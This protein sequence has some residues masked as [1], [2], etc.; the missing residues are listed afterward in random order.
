MYKFISKFGLYLV[1]FG[2]AI[3]ISSPAPA[4]LADG[5]S[6]WINGFGYQFLQGRLSPWP[7]GSN[8][9]TPLYQGDSL[10]LSQ[11]PV[12]GS[13]PGNDTVSIDC[14]NNGTYNDTASASS[15]RQYVNNTPYEYSSTNLR[16]T[17]PTSGTY[18]PRIHVVRTGK[19][20]GC[21]P[22]ANYSSY[23][24]W[25]DY[26]GVTETIDYYLSAFSV[27]S[28][29]YNVTVI[30][31]TEYHGFLANNFVCNSSTGCGAPVTMDLVIDVNTSKISYYGGP[32][33][34]YD[35]TGPFTYS[36]DC[37]GDGKIDKVVSG[38]A[39]WMTAYTNLQYDPNTYRSHGYWGFTNITAYDT[40]PVCS[41]TSPGVYNISVAVD[42]GGLPQTEYGRY[43]LMIFPSSPL[44][45]SV[46]TSPSTGEA[47]LNSVTVHAVANNIMPGTGTWGPVDLELSCEGNG[48]NNAGYDIDFNTPG[49]PMSSTLSYD[50][51][52]T[53]SCSY[54]TAGTHTPTV[55]VSQPLQNLSAS[56][57]AK[58]YV[59]GQLKCDGTD[60]M[61]APVNYRLDW[62]AENSS[63]C[64]ASTK[65]SQ[66]YSGM[67]Y[68]AA[69]NWTGTKA[70]AGSQT[71]YDVPAGNYEY[72][73]SCVGVDPS[74]SVQ[75]SC[76]VRVTQ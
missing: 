2:S 25:G 33:Y 59:V 28:Q 31:T 53:N 10:N 22:T 68:S 30:P 43:A 3:V 45:V 44:S 9:G 29:N 34:S 56:G 38:S 17:Y 21:G 19:G 74:Q 36:I 46:K 16:C 5:N 42:G 1:I 12:M 61:K 50:F 65:L 8:Y 27:L 66:S 63:K 23:Y 48:S 64:I 58:V 62:A 70:A 40:G 15:M 35:M 7:Y 72:D 13:F 75:S 69:T 20:P 41:Y 57:S 47:P 67:D 49:T 55:T 6:L 54:S 71:F 26:R 4:A 37:N 39:D 51:T 76:A 11:I 73:L 24:C 32:T 14:E 52:G 60:V 18:S